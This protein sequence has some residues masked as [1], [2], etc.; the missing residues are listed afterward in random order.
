MRQD[1]DNISLFLFVFSLA[2]TFFHIVPTFLPG[3]LK[4]P[5]TWGDAIDFL[6]PLAVIPLAFLV[7]IRARKALPGQDSPGSSLKI[8]RILA[9]ILLGLGFLFYVD[10]HG[11]HLASNAIARLLQ[12]MKQSELFRATYLFDEIISHLMLD[13][14]AFL[15]SVGLVLFSCRLAFKSLS[16]KNLVF[17]SLGAVFYGF[18]LTV[19]CIEG[20]TVLIYFPAAG[21]GF[22]VSLFLY[23]R[24]RK[25]SL[26]NPVLLFF[27]CGYLLSILLFSY[28]GISHSGFPQFS[29]LYWI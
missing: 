28:W 3:I 17:I 27:L 8:F 1:K 21:I 13:G 26:H 19:N 11:L 22:L 2:F 16:W 4:K 14:G 20:Q 29:E 25:H 10:G 18:T 24:N 12:G 5:L 6:T 9:Q 23:S 7:Y 15:I